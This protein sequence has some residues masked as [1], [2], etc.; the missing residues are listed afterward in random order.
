MSVF[1]GL[2]FTSSQIL[3]LFRLG[4]GSGSWA[5]T[6]FVKTVYASMYGP[7]FMYPLITLIVLVESYDADY[8]FDDSL[9][10]MAGAYFAL[11]MVTAVF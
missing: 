4:F 8:G 5:D 1:N 3:W 9:I 6:W 10:E 11:S 2:I 7:F